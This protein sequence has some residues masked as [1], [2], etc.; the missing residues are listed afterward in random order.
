M[1]PLKKKETRC[2]FC[3]LGCRVGFSQTPHGTVA[4]DHPTDVGELRRGVCNR[5]S[6]TAELL[7]HV[8]RRDAAK[9]ADGDR[10][11][12]VPLDKA[13]TRLADAAKSADTV[14]LI[15]GNLT[16]EDI[17]AGLALGA[18]SKGKV[19]VSVYLP[20][21]DEAVLD[22]LAAS[23]TKLL[24]PEALAECD[25]VLIVGDAFATHPVISRPVHHL[26]KEKRRLPLVVI[27]S[28]P[29]KTSI[30]ATHPL[31][32]K[33][34][35]ESR[36]L[37]AIAGEVGVKDVGELK[38][39][40]KTAASEAGVPEDA[41]S[42]AA[43]ALAAA[44]KLGV[45]LRGEIGKAANWDQVALL[46]GLIASEKAGGV[47]AC[48]T[49][50]NAVG[51]YRLA[52]AAGTTFE[53]A[54]ETTIVLGTDVVC[55]PSK[56]ESAALLEGVKTLGA[57]ARL[58][59]P[60]LGAADIVLPLAFNFET[61]GTTV[62]GSG[63]VITVDA[64]ADP[65]GHAAS[66]GELVMRLAKAMGI[67]GVERKLD[68]GILERIPE[69]DARTMAGKGHPEV[70]TAPQGAFL[71]VTQSDAVNFHT[72]SVSGQCAWPQYM[73]PEPVAAINADDAA[74]M[75]VDD[76]D[77]V[78]L[79]SDEGEGVATAAVVK[80]QAAGVVA[81]SSAFGRMRGLFPWD[82]ACGMGP[83]T[84]RIEKAGSET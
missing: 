44:K 28:V 70:Q 55:G 77:A 40:V 16:C 83:V 14:L 57:A 81:V 73:A 22:G 41:L 18:A 37:A 30:F 32:V 60:T 64:V 58:P 24:T 66:A 50:G 36:V 51:A 82:L 48:L 79:T 46:A 56:R 1:V 54:A 75:D 4:P 61:G 27:D 67:S 74:S 9:V 29:G 59:T 71:A 72:G 76:G 17:A 62:N 19:K 34:G 39:T 31:L 11:R 8:L 12:D 6:M 3:S 53:K 69:V 25:A 15:D 49:Y 68:P 80:A 65:P 10:P 47:T 38:L 78:K 42:A 45:I 20:N 13:I 7:G 63:E 52:R 35:T 5:G 2:T 23:K 43:A 84:V 26:R 21:E 33:P